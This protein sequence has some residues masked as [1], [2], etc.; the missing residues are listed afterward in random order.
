MAQAAKTKKNIV[1]HKSKTFRAMACRCR[2]NPSTVKISS[3]NA[4]LNNRTEE[5]IPQYAL[6]AAVE[7]KRAST[8][9]TTGCTESLV[10]S[11]A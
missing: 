6:K 8:I 2:V 1:D 10:K 9:H 5:F 7:E 4:I 11:S 3:K